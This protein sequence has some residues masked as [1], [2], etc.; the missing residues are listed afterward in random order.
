MI[1]SFARKLKLNLF[2]IL[3]ISLQGYGQDY[4]IPGEGEMLMISEVGDIKLS[5]VF[6]GEGIYSGQI[7]YSP[8]KHLSLNGSFIYDKTSSQSFTFAGPSER[9]S[10][11]YSANGSI[12]VYYFIK[13]KKAPPEHFFLS[14]D[15][16]MQQGLLFDLHAGYG[17]GEMKNFYE[18]SAQSSFDLHR[19]Y[20][21]AG[22]HWIFRIGSIS[23]A[24]RAVRL[25]YTNGKAN[26]ALNEEELRDLFQGGIQDNNPF[27]FMES[28]FRY[29]IGIKQVRIYTGVT[30][31]FQKDDIRPN[32]N[33]QVIITAGLV[34]E[35]D[36]IFNKKNKVTVEDEGVVD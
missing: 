35:L 20:L 18:R 17:L 9:T 26:G 12:G 27:S 4:Y 24:F 6:P 8:I 25:D 19:F 30:T 15:V 1:K 14:K 22:A 23:F 34:F 28:S 2:F 31:K 32:S 36:E 10:R 11:G 7:G 16:T 13:S 33:K 5:T 21:Q 3:L 29:Q